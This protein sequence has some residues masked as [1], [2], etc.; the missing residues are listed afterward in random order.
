MITR[1]EFEILGKSDFITFVNTAGETYTININDS[2]SSLDQRKVIQLFENILLGVSGVAV[3]Y[4]E[5]KLITFIGVSQIIDM[6]YNMKLILGYQDTTFPTSLTTAESVGTFTLTSVLYLLS[7]YGAFAVTQD[8]P[9]TD[10]VGLNTMA[11]IPNTFSNGVPIIA[12]GDTSVSM[13]PG[14]LN[15]VR[16]IL[17]DA[18]RVPVKLLCPMHIILSVSP[19]RNI[20]IQIPE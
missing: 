14:G 7:Q 20:E 3:T 2:Y 1:C 16:V 17:V 9:L 19:V 8:S 6:S 13:G 12:Y 5:N 15:C 4:T 11:T 18:N 10:V